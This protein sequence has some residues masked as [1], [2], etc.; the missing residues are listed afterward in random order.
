[1]GTCTECGMHT[2][3][4]TLYQDIECVYLYNE[5]ETE[6][7]YLKR[8]FKF[9]C[10]CDILACIGF[11][12]TP[13]PSPPYPL[14]LSPTLSPL[15]SPP[16]SP[17]PPTQS[18]QAFGTIQPTL[19]FWDSAPWGCPLPAP[20]LEGSPPCFSGTMACSPR[21]HPH[22]SPHTLRLLLEKWGSI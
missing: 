2:H 16:R 13:I 15:R 4:T 5:N 10:M 19:A 20:L 8:N 6:C 7:V 22:L 11:S 12:A 14:L 1:M 9:Y 21:Q 17:P 18:R 3:R